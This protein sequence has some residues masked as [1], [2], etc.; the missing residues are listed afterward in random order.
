MSQ[1]LDK[2]QTEGAAEAS[3]AAGAITLTAAAIAHVKS[4][5]KRHASEPAMRIGVRTSSCSAFAYTFELDD[6]STAA[7][8]VMEQDGVRVIVDPKSHA[9]LAGTEIDYRREGVQE[10]FHFENPNVKGTCGCGESFT[11]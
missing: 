1:V 3:R 5:A 11:V 8:L 9:F 7:D 2:Q 6:A 4:F 10:G